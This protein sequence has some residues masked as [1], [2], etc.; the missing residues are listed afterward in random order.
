MAEE[1]KA[2]EDAG[3]VKYGVQPD[4]LTK[5]ATVGVEEEARDCVICGRREGDCDHTRAPVKKD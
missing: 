3:M 5:E 1:K 4:T 2:S